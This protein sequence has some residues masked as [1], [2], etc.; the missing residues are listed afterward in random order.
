MEEVFLDPGFFWSWDRFKDRW[1]NLFGYP[2]ED[3]VITRVDVM[4]NVESLVCGNLKRSWM[5]DAKF[6][7]VR[8][9]PRL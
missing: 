1:I 3:L 5:K 9:M 4:N 7:K 6:L 8:C 2:E